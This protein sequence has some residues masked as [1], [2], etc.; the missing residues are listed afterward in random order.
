MR[1][2]K[3]IFSALIA[4]SASMC[5]TRNDSSNDIESEHATKSES[6]SLID[7]ELTPPPTTADLPLAYCQTFPT[8]PVCSECPKTAVEPACAGYTRPAP[9]TAKVP[10]KIT[11][12]G[13]VQHQGKPSPPPNSKVFANYNGAMAYT[14][15]DSNGTFRIQ[16]DGYGDDGDDSLSVCA[17]AMRFE[18]KC[19]FYNK[20]TGAKDGVSL[21][22]INFVMPRA[23]PKGICKMSDNQFTT[24][25]DEGGC[26][27]K[28]TRTIWSKPLRNSMTQEEAISF[29]RSSGEFGYRD[30]QLPDKNIM[31]EVNGPTKNRGHFN[32]TVTNRTFWSS[33]LGAKNKGYAFDFT[34]G[35][36]I[37]MPS[38]KKN[39]VICVRQ[40]L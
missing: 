15:V 27:H 1:F 16:I 3:I 17:Y 23:I 39:S 2:F 25:L 13:S 32:F 9:P 40:L 8:D 36:V 28:Q 20:N 12:V 31:L 11:I 22:N 14:T 35:I 30:W 5:R 37:Q 34:N 29:C 7:K 38:H 19:S 33:T 24:S 21:N 26:L 18:T 6:N 4:L 10:R